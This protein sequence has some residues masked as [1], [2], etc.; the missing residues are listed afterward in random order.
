MGEDH[1]FKD[2]FGTENAKRRAEFW[3]QA[4]REGTG[5]RFGS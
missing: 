4:E 1:Q 5:Y 3:E 2:D